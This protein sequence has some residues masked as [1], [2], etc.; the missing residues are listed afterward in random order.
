MKEGGKKGREGTDG[1]R[2]KSKGGRKGERK[3]GREGSERN[4][5]HEIAVKF[6]LKRLPLDPHLKTKA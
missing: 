5:N 2:K 6:F 3:G 4:I 1:G